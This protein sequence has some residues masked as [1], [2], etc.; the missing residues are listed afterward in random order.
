MYNGYLDRKAMVVDAF[1]VFIVW[2]F[3][4]MVFVLAIVLAIVWIPAYI[5]YKIIQHLV[6]GGEA[7]ALSV[8]HL[9]RQDGTDPLPAR[10]AD[11]G[12]AVS[13]RP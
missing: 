2:P 13:D 1:T 6:K 10:A 12:S 7:H 8:E 9:D 5:I 11:A 3:Y 4:A